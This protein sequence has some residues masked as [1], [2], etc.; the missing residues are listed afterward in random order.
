MRKL[1]HREDEYLVQIT[2]LLSK[3]GFESMHPN[4]KADFLTNIPHFLLGKENYL[5][6]KHVLSVMLGAF[7]HFLLNVY[8]NH[9]SSYYQSSDFFVL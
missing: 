9:L 6:N 4:Y 7:T 5:L 3:E 1:T 8:N 2:G